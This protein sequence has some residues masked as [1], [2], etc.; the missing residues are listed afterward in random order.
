MSKILLIHPPFGTGD[1]KRPPDIF[2]PHFPWG[3][4]C[5]TGILRQNGFDMDL[6]DIY[7]HQWN[8]QEALKGLEEKS[9]DC[10]MIT[11]MATQYVYIKWLS[12]QLKRIN[13]SCKIILGGQLAT[14]SY[15]AVLKNTDIEG[16]DTP[17]VVLK[18]D[19]SNPEWT[20]V[21]RVQPTTSE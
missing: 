21:S 2:D 12:R 1:D 4:G 10:V 3:L 20:E 14:F 7:A 13:G 16:D 8:R 17:V 6:F 19:D 5:I 9:F 15:D 18:S 11:A